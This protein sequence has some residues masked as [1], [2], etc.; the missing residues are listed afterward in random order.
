MPDQTPPTTSPPISVG[1]PTE[2]TGAAGFDAAACT[3]NGSELYGPIRVVEVP[4]AA[5]VKVYITNALP[6]LSVYYVNASW[7]ATSCG[8]WWLTDHPLVQALNVYFAQSSF[9][10]DITIRETAAS[11]QAGT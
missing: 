5:D 11:F 8:L 7:G 2:P 6:D 9:G 10:A 1:R 3:F 4:E